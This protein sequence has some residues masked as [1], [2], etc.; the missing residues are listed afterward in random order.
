MNIEDD[1]KKRIGKF[2]ESRIDI[3]DNRYSYESDKVI[4]QGI[5]ELITNG[6]YTIKQLQRYAL[7]EELVFIPEKFIEQ[8]ARS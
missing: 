6:V 5:R 7:S 8:C 2:L 1:Y 4:R 3:L